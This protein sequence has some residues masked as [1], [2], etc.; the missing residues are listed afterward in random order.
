MVNNKNKNTLHIYR[1]FSKSI[2]ININKI[3]KQF[4]FCTSKKK[5]VTE[6]STVNSA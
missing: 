6:T 2:K 4:L 5:N 1:G 3:E